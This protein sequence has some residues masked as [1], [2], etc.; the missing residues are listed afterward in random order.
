MCAVS[1]NLDFF[2]I[3]EEGHRTFFELMG[4][5]GLNLQIIL[6]YPS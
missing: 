4:R 5:F 1:L 3:L 6:I 2:L